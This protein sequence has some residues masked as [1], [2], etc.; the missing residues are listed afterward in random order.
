MAE[1]QLWYDKYRPRTLDDYVWEDDRLKSQVVEWIDKKSIPSF[2]LAGGPGRGKTSLADLIIIS[3]GIDE[4][5]V[6]R[7]KGAKHN[8]ADTIRTR[9][10]E[11]CEL[12]GWSGIRVVFFDEA[13]LLSRVAQEMLR[14]VIDEYSDTVRFIFTCNYPHRIIEALST[15]RLVRIDIEKLPLAEYEDRLVHI[16][17]AE[18]IDI[19]DGSA[20]EEIRDTCY[21]DLRRA[22]NTLQSS[23]KDRKLQRVHGL[24]SA[25]GVWES[26]LRE[27]IMNRVAP[28]DVICRVRELL[29]TLTPDEMEDVYRFLYHNGAILFGDKQIDALYQINNAQVFHRQALFPDMLLLEVIIR[30]LTLFHK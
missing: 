24:K 25:A 16:V 5:D 28:L 19:G 12:G 1:V 30:V 11:F 21:P 29:I 17:A 26:Y 20:L 18:G 13:D 22:I 3:L 2:M 7:L 23:I 8:N 4:S 15:S 6:L 9:V 10:Q 14:N 27:I